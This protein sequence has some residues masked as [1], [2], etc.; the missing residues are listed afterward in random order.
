MKEHSNRC[1]AVFFANHNFTGV[2][3]FV[4]FFIRCA[5]YFAVNDRVLPCMHSS[6]SA[7]LT[8]YGLVV[9]LVV[10]QSLT[11][12]CLTIYL[13]HRSFVSILCFIIWLCLCLLI[14]FVCFSNF[15]TSVSQV[16][17]ACAGFLYL[18]YFFPVCYRFGLSQ[19]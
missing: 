12:L 4:W 19:K 17:C 15:S 8:N 2:V 11:C 13:Q 5:Y 3:H 10:N 6:V 14:N 16:R 18:A 1:D 7:S 9:M